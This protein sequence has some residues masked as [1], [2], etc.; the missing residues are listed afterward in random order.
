VG[1]PKIKHLRVVGFEKPFGSLTEAHEE[2][3]SIWPEALDILSTEIGKSLVRYSILKQSDDT[4][5]ADL[6]L[7]N[8]DQLKAIRDEKGRETPLARAFGI[9]GSVCFVVWHGAGFGWELVK[10]GGFLM[11]VETW[12]KRHFR[13]GQKVEQKCRALGWSPNL[14]VENTRGQRRMG[15]VRDLEALLA[16][17]A[18]KRA[19]MLR[20]E[21]LLTETH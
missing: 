16:K 19:A 1:K 17:D 14:E 4:L 10:G 20:P 21:R 11:F 18:E 12:P 5:E 2:L 9:K 13:R 15:S 3:R 7:L 8:L 6:K